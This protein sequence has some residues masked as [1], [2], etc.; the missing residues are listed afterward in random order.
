MNRT[1][2]FPFESALV[3]AIM[4]TA[5]GSD[6]IENNAGAT[7]PRASD[8]SCLALGHKVSTSAQASGVN[9][10]MRVTV[11]QSPALQGGTDPRREGVVLGD[12]FRS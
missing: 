3:A 1:A 7:S 9:T 4:M 8:A 5:C 12:R 6:D 10:V 11:G 2:I